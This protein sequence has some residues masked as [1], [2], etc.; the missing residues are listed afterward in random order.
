MELKILDI[1]KKYEDIYALN[2]VTLALV[3]GIYALLGPNGAG[4]TTLM[5]ILTG[6]LKADSGQIL[7][8]GTTVSSNSSEYKK[9][10]GYV[11]QQQALYPEFTVRQYLMYLS[12]LK[13]LKKKDAKIRIQ[14]VL[15]KVSMLEYI[16]KKIKKLS[17]GMKQ[18]VLIAQALLCD[19][20]LLILDEPTA[21][22]DPEQRI[23]IRNLISEISSQRIVL[24]ATHIV[25]DVE[26][27]AKNII[28]LSRGRL[29]CAKTREDLLAQING[30]VWELSGSLEMYHSLQK[31]Y[32]VSEIQPS[33][34][35]YII[36]FISLKRPDLPDVSLVTPQ[37]NDI[38]LWYFGHDQ[39]DC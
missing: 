2:H 19:P 4:K 11:P 31:K 18:R 17:G 20:K 13:G 12:E 28:L 7:L 26:L 30:K 23:T 5:N 25:S 3:P 35:G 34:E 16:E 10:L 27:I 39:S 32:T 36:R 6:N 1:T 9:F 14:S 8:N 24:I 38:Y 33:K 29:I 21:G 15:Q 22:L 37:L